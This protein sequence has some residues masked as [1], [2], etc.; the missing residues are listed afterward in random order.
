MKS[1]LIL[2]GLIEFCLANR[3]SVMCKNCKH[4]IP[5]YFKED[6]LLQEYYGKC[7]KFEIVKNNEIE[8]E[9]IYKLREKF[10]SCGV[11]AKYFTPKD[12]KDELSHY[13]ID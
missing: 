7:K 4:F 2:Y 1:I 11:H 12:S 3:F 9:Y 5:P 10:G 13:Y 8:Y 6:T